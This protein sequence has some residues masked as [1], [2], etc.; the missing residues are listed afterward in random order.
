MQVMQEK[1][2]QESLNFS[3][4][5]PED[6]YSRKNYRQQILHYTKKVTQ[7]CTKPRSAKSLQYL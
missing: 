1:V 5:A 7:I 6:L 4:K 3:L 2:Y